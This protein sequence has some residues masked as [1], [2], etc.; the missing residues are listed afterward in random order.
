RGCDSSG[1][2]AR[3]VRRCGAAGAR[4]GVPGYA[5]APGAGLP[6]PAAGRPGPAGSPPSCAGSGPRRRRGS[7]GDLAHTHPVVVVGED[8]LDAAVVRG[9]QLLELRLGQFGPVDVRHEEVIAEGR[10]RWPGSGPTSSS[11]RTLP[12]RPASKSERRSRSLRIIPGTA[13]SEAEPVLVQ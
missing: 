11:T 10:R 3:Q 8:E 9:Q 4:E 12:R 6:G 5:G 1:F 2:A 13:G 7:R